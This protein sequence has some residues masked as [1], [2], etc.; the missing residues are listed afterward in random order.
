MRQS[1]IKGLGL[2]Y[3]HCIS[4]IVGREF[5]L[6]DDEKEHFLVLMRRLEAFHGVR[7]VT[8]CVMSNH[9]HLLLEVPDPATTAALDRETI[10]HRIG[11]LYDDFTVET[12][13]QELARA[14]AAGNT[15]W[16]NE[17]L[18]RYRS[19]MGN[20]STFLQELKQRFSAW[21]NRRHHRKGTLW[22]E[23]FKSVL[24][25]GDEKALMTIAAYIDLNP[26]RAH[27]VGKVEDYRWSGY[28]SAVS[29]NHWAR[30]GLGRILRNSPQVSGEDYEQNWSETGKVYRLWLYDQG[31]VR[32]ISESGKR[33]E[34]GG[35]TQAEVEAER[36]ISGKIPLHRIIRLRVRYLSDGAV[37]GSAAFVESVFERHRFLF[38]EKRKTG[39]RK[40][41]GADW[42]GLRVLRDLRVE[43]TG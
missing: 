30:I 3:Y 13:R 20:L 39:A 36:E 34:K 33:P 24:V 25:E 26:I 2:S 9:F 22:E 31:E 21:Y 32:E 15:R 41:K 37:F 14:D 28:A 11:L 1:R 29:G 40:M 10:L 16:E 38:G 19:R 5:L 35:F 7:A 18:E 27:M 6:G 12:V 8:Y 4:R 17:I 42:Q 43:R 23:R